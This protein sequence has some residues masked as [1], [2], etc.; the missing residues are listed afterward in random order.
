VVVFIFFLYLPINPAST[1]GQLR[2]IL[3]LSPALII[4]FYYDY[5]ELSEAFIRVCIFTLLLSILLFYCGIG[6]SDTYGES[7]MRMQGLLSEPSAMAIIIAPVFLCGIAYKRIQLLMLSIAGMFLSLSP[8]VVFVSL[9]SLIVYLFSGVK[10]FLYKVILAVLITI[11]FIAFIYILKTGGGDFQ[12]YFVLGRLF[13]GILNIITLGEAG[14]NPRFSQSMKMI[15]LL[16]EKGGVWFGL[17]FNSADILEER[18]L[19]L[20]FE[21]LF[22]F[23]AIGLLIL[24][25]TVLYI[26]FNSSPSKNFNIA[27]SSLFVYC[28]ANS[29]QGITIQILLFILIICFFNKKHLAKER[30]L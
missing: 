30:G 6:V 21:M 24:I 26:I 2:F 13:D 9:A 20:L 19:S 3:F 16:S 17:G 1:T 18:A 7:N 4:P 29:A 22:S 28:F 14:Y 5:S 25:L 12:G 8:T 27:F 10:S 15:E 23:G 11:I